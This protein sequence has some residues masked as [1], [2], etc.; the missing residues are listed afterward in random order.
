MFA[1][2][3]EKGHDPGATRYS[4]SSFDAESARYANLICG[5]SF[6]PET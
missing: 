3:S 4:C 5:G 1:T 2:N 6:S